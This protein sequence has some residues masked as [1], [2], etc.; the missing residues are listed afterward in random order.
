MKDLQTFTV[1]NSR[2]Y[3]EK[4]L[5][6]NN[7][8][9]SKITK[10]EKMKKLLLLCG[11][12]L[13]S[14]TAMAEGTEPEKVDVTQLVKI[15]FEG[16]DVILHYKNGTTSSAKS[17][18]TVVIDF[19]SVTSIETIRQVESMKNMGVYN[20]QGQHVGNGVEGLKKGLYIVGG[21]KVIIK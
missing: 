11:M 21:K 4:Y 13:L 3:D 14:M 17:M 7:F 12:F 18:E 6:I 16:D 5:I 9:P 10:S 1:N 15:T 19:S 20:L 2:N 8:A